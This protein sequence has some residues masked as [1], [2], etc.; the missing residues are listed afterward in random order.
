MVQRV[1]AILSNKLTAKKHYILPYQ[2]F[3]LLPKNFHGTLQIVR[4]NVQ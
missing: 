1:L 3:R 2:L 4:N